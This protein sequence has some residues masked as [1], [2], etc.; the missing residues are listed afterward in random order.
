MAVCKNAW[1]SGFRS[2]A[3]MNPLPPPDIPPSIQKPQKSGPKR[4]RT[5]AISDSVKWFEA[6]GM[7]A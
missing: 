1:A 3:T 6:A 4:V 7:I 5:A 2:G